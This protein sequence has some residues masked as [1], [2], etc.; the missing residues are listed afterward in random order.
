MRQWLPPLV[1]CVVLSLGLTEIRGDES[2]ADIACRSVHLS[3]PAGEGVAFYNEV[4]VEQSAPGTYFCVCGWDKGY[5]GIQELGNGKKVVIFSVWDSKQNDPKAV[6]EDRR[7]KLLHK[8]EKVRT[9]RFGGEGT[10]GQSFLDYDWQVGDTYRFLVTAKVNGDRTEYSGYIC[11][12]KE[13]DWKHLVTFSTVTG[14]KNLGGYYA[15]I[16]DF[17]RDRDSTTKIRKARFA[18]TWVKTPKEEWEAV[19]T[20]KFTADRN[21]ATNINAGVKDDQ[22]FLSTGGDTKNADTKLNE[23]MKLPPNDKKT[24]PAGLPSAAEPKPAPPTAHAE[25]VIHV[26]PT[27][28]DTNSGTAEK[29]VRTPLGARN[30]VRTVKAK[31]LEPITV[32]FAPGTYYLADT[33][34]LGP[35]DSGTEKAPVTYVASADGPVILS[36]GVKLDLQWKPYKDGIMQAESAAPRDGKGTFDQLFV[37]G[38]NMPL[39]R[40]PNYKAD[41]RPFNG[42]AADAINPEERVEKQ[43]QGQPLEIGLCSC[44]AR[45]RLGRPPLPNPPARRQQRRREARKNGWQN[46][47]RSK[48]HIQ[49]W[50]HKS[51][52][53]L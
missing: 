30:L 16:E 11:A 9:G 41:A 45:Q 29:P 17:K 50:R 52:D 33:F 14:G 26:A 39:A 20:A 7:V 23:S 53:D 12:A 44:P 22:F 10:G 47:R 25:M 37:N 19:T 18:N 46:N 42:T 6:E 27:G 28:D 24:V 34:L 3:Y 38:R 36:G 40:Y 49:H 51:K 5:Y 48:M 32:R 15:F 31:S 13:K 8:D 2:L 1:A 43:H 21:P 4:T 35:E